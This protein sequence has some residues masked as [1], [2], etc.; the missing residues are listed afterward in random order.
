VPSPVWLL[1]FAVVIA[2]SLAIA[3]EAYIATLS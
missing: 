1:L 2:G 3:A